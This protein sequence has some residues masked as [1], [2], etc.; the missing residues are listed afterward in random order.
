MSRVFRDE[1]TDEMEEAL[2]SDT[3]LG[4]AISSYY[5]DY[6]N[7]EQAFSLEDQAVTLEEVVRTGLKDPEYTALNLSLKATIQ[8]GFPE[9]REECP[10]FS[11]HTTTTE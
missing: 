10:P 6:V 2:D 7:E 4:A 1:K 5:I 8:Q 3:E 9:N 11:H